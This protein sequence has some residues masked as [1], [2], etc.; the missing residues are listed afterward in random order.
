MDAIKT[1]GNGPY[2]VRDPRSKLPISVD[3]SAWLTRENT[4]IASSSWT[5]DPGV[6]LE[7]PGFTTTLA[8]VIVSGGTAGATYVIRNTITCAN[9]IVDSRSIRVVTRDR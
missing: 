4:T 5:S 2:L 1:D 7:S 3:W 6:T 9:G 8:S